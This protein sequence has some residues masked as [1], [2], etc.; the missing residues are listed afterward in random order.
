[1]TLTPI[2]P[3]KVIMPTNAPSNPVLMKGMDSV[4]IAGYAAEKIATALL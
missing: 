4:D 2:M 1:M 3:T